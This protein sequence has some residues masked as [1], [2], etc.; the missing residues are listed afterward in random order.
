MATTSVPLPRAAARVRTRQLP[1]A[2][3]VGLAAGAAA[4]LVWVIAVAIFD[5]HL[6]M[7]STPVGPAVA[8]GMLLATRGTRGRLL[9]AGALVV[10]LVL[11]LSAEYFAVRSLGVS[12]LEEQGITGIPLL[13]DPRTSWNL[14][15]AGVVADPI[16]PAFFGASLWLALIL[17]APNR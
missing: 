6:G 10:T 13:L 8:G 7:L 2:V 5:A 1:A 15:A 11:L 16:T 4:A 9:Q 17:P 12:F 3:G 14:V